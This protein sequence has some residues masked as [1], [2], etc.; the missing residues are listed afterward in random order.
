MARHRELFSRYV[1]PQW[2]RLIVLTVLLFGNIAI[3]LIAPLWVSRF[4]DGVQSGATNSALITI[5]ILFMVFTAARP[6]VMGI[7]GYLSEDVGWRSTNRLRTDLVRH[8]LNLD[9]SF[10]RKHTPGELMERV[11]GDVSELAEFLSFFVFGVVGRALL[12]VGI[13]VMAFLVDYRIGLT[14]LV[15]AAAVLIILRTTQRLAVPKSQALR[16]AKA[17]MSSFLEERLGGRETIRANGGRDHLF[18]EMDG[19]IGVLVRRTRDA[20]VASRYS[21][22]LLELMVALSAVAVLA[23]GAYLLPSSSITLGEIYLGYYYTDLLSHSLIVVTMHMEGLQRASAAIRRIGELTAIQPTVVSGPGHEPDRGSLDIEFENVDFGYGGTQRALDGVSFRLAAGQTLGLLGRTGSGKTTI[24]RLICREQD[25][26]GGAVRIGGADIRDYSL[27]QLRGLV[28]M[29]TQ[30]VQLLHATLRDNLTFFDDS[31][32]D[33]R[34]FAALDELQLRKWYE[35]LPDGL[36]TVLVD[37]GGS[38]SAGE[39]QLVALTR[40][41]LNDPDVV[42]LDEASSRLD[43]ATERLVE[44]ATGRLLEGRTGVVVA[45]RLNTV[46]TLDHIAV[47]DQGRIQEIGEQ[48]KLSAD[49][50]SRFATLLAGGTS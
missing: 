14:L 9:L 31:V 30:D 12:S 36:D 42:V 24:A 37:G 26:T 18:D 27:P 23:L 22:S 13:I 11:D 41:F 3:E 15:A 1:R 5:A 16:A 40:A 44:A 39:A 8:C 32:S 2:P 48:T 49:P 35:S 50:T 21:S 29:V 47:L 43:P 19:R 34:L 6:I 20:M 46:R 45:H 28:T 38:L 10:H 7:A 33:E 17:D 25:A 4:I